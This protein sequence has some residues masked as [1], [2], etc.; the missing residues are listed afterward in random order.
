MIGFKL[1][2]PK[3]RCNFLNTL[4]TNTG[5]LKFKLAVV[6]IFVLCVRQMIRSC[7]MFPA[8]LTSSVY[9]HFAL[10]TQYRM[11]CI[12]CSECISFLWLL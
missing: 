3:I 12:P 11:L 2:D 5:E 7:L 4:K 10:Y 9:L 1:L 8:V 6:L